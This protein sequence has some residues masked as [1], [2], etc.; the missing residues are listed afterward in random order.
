M[1]GVNVALEPLTISLS[2]KVWSND[3]YLSEAILSYASSIFLKRL[4]SSTAIF[5]FINLWKVAGTDQLLTI[6]FQ[7]PHDC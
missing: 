3:N 7:Q 5:Y 1:E 6:L 4:T 2:Y